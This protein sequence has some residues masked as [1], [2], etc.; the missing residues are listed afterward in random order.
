MAGVSDLLLLTLG[1]LGAVL[2]CLA[3]PCPP[4][5]W[6]VVKPSRP[7]PLPEPVDVEEA[8]DRDSEPG[9]ADGLTGVAA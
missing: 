4:E 2:A 3:R 8:L 7:E 6:S 5:Q 1:L 9:F